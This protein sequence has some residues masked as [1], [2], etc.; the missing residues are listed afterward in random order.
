MD[1]APESERKKHTCVGNA[2]LFTAKENSGHF[3][4]VL[5]ADQITV[6]WNES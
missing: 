5:L 3:D 6:I 1:F 2:N 4:F